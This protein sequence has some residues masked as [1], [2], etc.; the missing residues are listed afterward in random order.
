MSASQGAATADDPR[1]EEPRRPPDRGLRHTAREQTF[2]SSLALG[3]GT[4]GLVLVFAGSAAVATA[5]GWTPTENL[6]QAITSTAQLAVLLAT[7]GL[8]ALA[9]VVGLVGARTARTKLAREGSISGAFLGLQ[10]IALATFLLWF[11]S[12]DV[13]RFARQFFDF[14]LLSDFWERFLRAAG[15]T[16][17]LALSGEAIGIGLGLLF[18]VF[19]LSSRAVV[20]APARAY[21]NFFRGTPLLWQLSFFFFGIVLGLQLDVGVYTVAILVFGL[22]AGAYSAE[23]FRAGIQSIERGQFE[24]ARSLG[25]SYL[26][27]LR[28]VI[29]PQAIRRVIPPLTNEFVI[30]IKDTSL[31]VVLGL[32]L[33]QQE[34]LSTARDIY[35]QTFNAT[36]FLAAAAG[37]LAITLPMI[38]VVTWLE[39]RL[40]SGLTGIG[41]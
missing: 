25:M 8:G 9:V 41:A 20:R 30:L 33:S 27:A 2:A 12:G 11:R 17:V 38:R 4:G 40:R 34:L 19:A 3:A 21:I 37:Y 36:P 15:N 7:I 23:I 24:A 35:A 32:T 10:A 5:Y 13:E 16:V 14:A 29:L 18:S 31:V 28:L 26:K 39:R 6:T 1:P 22:N